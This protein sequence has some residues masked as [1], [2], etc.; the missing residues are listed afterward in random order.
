MK[1]HNKIRYFFNKMTSEWWD[2]D[3]DEV[4]SKLKSI[5]KGV[6]CLSIISRV[7]LAC[8]ISLDAAYKTCNIGIP[9]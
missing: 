1:C 2:K 4:Y 5:M 6:M 3:I 9:L 8:I 7:L